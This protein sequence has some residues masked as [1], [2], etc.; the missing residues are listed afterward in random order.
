LLQNVHNNVLIAKW[1]GRDQTLKNTGYGYLRERNTP[2]RQRFSILIAAREKT[3]NRK[4]PN[5]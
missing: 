3:R 1:Q 5:W 2:H 4:R